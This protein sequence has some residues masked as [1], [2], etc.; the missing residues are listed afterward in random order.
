MPALGVGPILVGLF[1]AVFLVVFIAAPVIRLLIEGGAAALPG[2]AGAL[3]QDDYLRW[4]VVWTFVQAALT[5]LAALVLGVPIAW[6][7]ARHD[8]AGRALVLRLLMLPFVVPTLVAALGVLAL[9]G[10]RGLLAGWLGVNLQDTPWLLLYGNLF[11]NLCVLV[12][13]GVDAL[14]QVSAARVAAART[15]GATPWRAF[16]RVEWPAIA[17]WL[18]SALCLVFLYCFSGFG[19]AL[20]LGGQHFATMEVEIYTLVAH[21]LKLAEAG[22][23]AMI[24]LLLTGGVALAYALVEK[25]LAT[26]ARADRIARRRPQGWR[27]WGLVG[28]A[29]AV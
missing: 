26:P 14:T 7:L 23:L 3:W 21:E 28:A 9:W 24:M 11:F 8:F 16:W 18:A 12:R 6:V 22:S 19:L 2:M 27:Q 1:P 4:R 20:I 17:P 13:A 10:P 15:L 5:C 29:M 25:R